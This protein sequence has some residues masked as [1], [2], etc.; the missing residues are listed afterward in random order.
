MNP[1]RAAN[2]P[3][4]LLRS[5][6]IAPRHHDR[7]AV[8]YVRQST[9]Q[10]VLDHQE[11]T[12]LQYGL[13]A[14]AQDLGWAAERVVVIDDDLGQSG[15]SAEARVGFQRLVSE[16][17]LDHVGLVLGVDMSRLARSSKDWHQLLEICA[18]F[19][20]LIADLDGVYD[21]GQYNDRLLLGL[22]GTMSEAE[23]H[24]LKQRMEQG[25]LSK[26]RR[27]ELA[28]PVP[29]GYLRRP[30]GEVVL[31][32]DEQVQEVVRLIFRKFAELGTLN[33]VLRYLVRHHVQLGIRV[34]EGPGKGELEWRRPNRMTLQNLLK[35]PLYAGAYAYGRRQVDPRTARPGRPSTG[36]RVIAPDGWYVLLRDHGPAYISWE[37]YE[38]NLARLKANQARAEEVGVARKGAALLAGLVICAKCGRRLHVRYGGRCNRHTYIC[39]RLMSDYG[40]EICQQLAGPPLDTLVSTW[41]LDALTPAA[42]DLSLAAATNLER[43]RA[44]LVRLWEQRLERAAYEAERAARQYRRC[45]PENRL[46]ARQLERDWEG[47]LAAQQHLREEYRRF[48][49]QQPRLLSAAEQAAIRRLAQDIPALWAAAT[50]TVAERKEIVRQVVERVV[51][52]A[53]GASERVQVRVTWV[54]GVQT[55]GELIRPVARLTQLS[56]YSQLCARAQVLA[57]EGLTA[58]AIA[59][60]LNA[61]G[62]RPP[63]R[64]EQFGR[65]GVQELLRDLGVRAPRARL[66]PRDGL[67]PEEWWVAELAQRV[68]MPL[69]TLQG[70]IRRGWV[71]ARQQEHAPHRWIVWADEAEVARLR[72]RHQ[73]PAGYHTRRLW[74]DEVSDCAD[75]DPVIRM[76]SS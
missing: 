3:A 74:V 15:A 63:K 5:E 58:E 68:G 66:A 27:G 8:V 57:G 2:P 36:R 13:A 67:G 76:A 75:S 40:G 39:S 62:Y 50:T 72:Q 46:V 43:E 29:S 60:R 48:E 30:S 64:R 47:A 45:E 65:Q 16:V 26:A 53:E 17:S 11:S 52:D 14:R 44:D 54:G 38:R 12:R 25:R 61:E 70:W 18:L 6:K 23:L 21:P 24:I 31:D 55:A 28:V 49:Q 71:R 32:P 41:V 56:Y 59:A 69:A 1:P 10:Q 19:G 22:K 7:L 51:I 35:N 34:R 33:A 20:T 4:G 9:V 73:R 42:L 37:Q